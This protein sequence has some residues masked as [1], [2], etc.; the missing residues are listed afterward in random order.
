MTPETFPFGKHSGRTPQEIIDGGD[1]GYLEWAATTDIPTRHP[2]LGAAIQ[3]ALEAPTSIDTSLEPREPVALEARVRGGGQMLD[4]T[5]LHPVNDQGFTG[6]AI[7]TTDGRSGSG[8]SGSVIY[9]GMPPDG[10]YV[11]RSCSGSINNPTV[12]E[13][14]ICIRDGQW[15]TLTSQT[16][17]AAAAIATQEA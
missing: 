7:T 5:T 12:S 9:E 16:R 1:R 3:A 6:Y 8:R 2:E 13:E 4:G 15:F 11:L 10:V 14:Y 17:D